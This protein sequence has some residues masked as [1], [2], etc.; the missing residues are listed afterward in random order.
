M[1]CKKQDSNRN[2]ADHPNT[3]C[4]DVPLTECKPELSDR[5]EQQKL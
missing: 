3:R 4:I 5:K 1:V 2:C